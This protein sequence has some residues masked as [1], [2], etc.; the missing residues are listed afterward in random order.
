MSK[1]EKHACVIDQKLF[2]QI[3]KKKSRNGLAF[4]QPNQT[5]W[6]LFQSHFLYLIQLLLQKYLKT[7]YFLSELF[8]LCPTTTK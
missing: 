4:F 5:F 8:E 1:K 7:L 2:W 3:T 6:H